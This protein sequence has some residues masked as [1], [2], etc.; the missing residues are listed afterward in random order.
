MHLVRMYSLSAPR[1]HWCRL[2]AQ[3]HWLPKT[4]STRAAR[5]LPPRAQATR[6][7]AGCGTRHCCL[8]YAFI[9]ASSE[10]IGSKLLNS[11]AG[12]E[13]VQCNSA[14]QQCAARYTSACK[15]HRRDTTRPY[16][17]ERVKRQRCTPTSATAE[18]RRKPAAGSRRRAPA[19]PPSGRAGPTSSPGSRQSRSSS[20][21]VWKS[22]SAS[23]APDDS[24]LSH[25]STMTPRR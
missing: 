20:G 16:C 9:I 25:F 11:F 14:P 18:R 5:L 3:N 6:T 2:R 13:S 22:T 17:C 4:P 19:R 10:L 21:S 23:G 12:Q 15:R 1:N 24:S 8:L 7:S